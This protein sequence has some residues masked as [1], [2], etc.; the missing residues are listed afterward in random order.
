MSAL[1]LY[2]TRCILYCTGVPKSKTGLSDLKLSC[3]QA[4]FILETQKL[5]HCIFQ[6]L[7]ADC[8]S[9]PPLTLKAS[10]VASLY[11]SLARTL[12]LSSLNYN[13]SYDYYGPSR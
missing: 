9:W 4:V 13:D 7:E 10:R 2:K 6:I 8:L 1:I 11:F 3:L 5:V 12:L